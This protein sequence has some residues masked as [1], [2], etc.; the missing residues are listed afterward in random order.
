M[1][2]LIYISLFCCLGAYS[3][4]IETIS[5]KTTTM[6]DRIALTIPLKEFQKMG[7]EAD[8]IADATPEDLCGLKGMDDAKILYYKGVKYILKNDTLTFRSVD[9][10][11]RRYMY[12]AT[13]DDW[14][15]H[16]TTFKTFAKTYPGAAAYP[17]YAEDED[18]TEYDL[19]SMLPAEAED[20]SEWRFYFQNGKLH[21]LE[22]W[23][24]CE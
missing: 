4:D 1:K 12:L 16:T 9:F 14:F 6:N 19:Y 7:R 15:D 21:H 17:D 2:L 20:E 5:W 10:S 13:E 11:K 3:Q 8:S 23:S 22:Y 24:P 18:G